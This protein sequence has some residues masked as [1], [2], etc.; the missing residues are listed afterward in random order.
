MNQARDSHP[1]RESWRSFGDRRDL[2][3]PV[4]AD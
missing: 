1:G 3:Y 4:V 2:T